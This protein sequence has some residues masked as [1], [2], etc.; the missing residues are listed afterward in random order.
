VGNARTPDI[1]LAT[2][3]AIPFPFPSPVITSMQGPIVIYCRLVIAGTP[4]EM[5]MPGLFAVGMP[6]TVGI[7]RR[8]ETVVGMLMVG[9]MTGILVAM[10]MNN[11]GECEEIPRERYLRRQ[12][13]SDS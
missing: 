8:A 10:R 9:T 13:H 2:K 6:M 7:L 5:V 12:R 3:I 1:I 4:C 11:A